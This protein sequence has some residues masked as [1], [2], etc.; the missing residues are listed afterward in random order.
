MKRFTLLPTVGI[1]LATLFATFASAQNAPLGDY[2]RQARKQ[3]DH[4]APAAKTFDNDNLPRPTSCRWLDRRLRR[5]PM[6]ALPQT[7]KRR[8]HQTATRKLHRRRVRRLIPPGP[9]PPRPGRNRPKM[10]SPRSR[11]CTKTGR[12]GFRTADPARQPGSRTGC[13]QPRVPPARCRL[14]CG[15][16][17]SLAQLR[18]MG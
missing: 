8:L 10:R 12:P 14:L 2:A 3:K 15:R 18:K 4:Q 13:H 7:A 11:R 17:Q 1:F 9:K 6:P 16:G 5:T